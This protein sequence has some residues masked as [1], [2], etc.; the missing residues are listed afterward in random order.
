MI[1]YFCK[2]IDL[3]WIFE[4]MQITLVLKFNKSSIIACSQLRMLPTCVWVVGTTLKLYLF[5]K[6]SLWHKNSKCEQH[7]AQHEHVLSFIKEKLRMLGK[8]LSSPENVR[9]TSCRRRNSTV[10][11]KNSL[12]SHNLMR[13]NVNSQ[14]FRWKIFQ[15]TLKRGIHSGRDFV[16]FRDFLLHFQKNSRPSDLMRL[17][18]LWDFSIQQ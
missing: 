10:T 18:C 12:K 16:L 5:C 8:F 4:N 1:K 13:R 11:M 15:Q 2:F 3:A 17:V 9:A 7:A 6:F 14:R